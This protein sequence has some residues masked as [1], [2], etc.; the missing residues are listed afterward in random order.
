MVQAAR[1]QRI[2][3]ESRDYNLRTSRTDSTPDAA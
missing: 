3:T 1:A 2:R